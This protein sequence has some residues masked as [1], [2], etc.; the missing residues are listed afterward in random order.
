M[1]LRQSLIPALLTLSTLASAEEVTPTVTATGAAS[2]GADDTARFSYRIG[3]VNYEYDLYTLGEIDTV[4]FEAMVNGCNNFIGGHC[5]S[6]NQNY[7]DELFVTLK[8][9]GNQVWSDNFLV[10]AHNPQLIGTTYTIGGTATD[11]ML[12]FQ[13]YDKGYWAGNYGPTISDVTLSVATL[14]GIIDYGSVYDVPYMAEIELF[15]ETFTPFE[16]MFIPEFDM[17]T[18]DLDYMSDNETVEPE[19][20]VEVDTEMA[21]SDF[22]YTEED[23]AM[24]EDPLITETTI[25]DDLTI[26]DVTE[27]E[28]EQAIVEVSSTNATVNDIADVI[29]STYDPITQ[30]VALQIMTVDA[31]E[32][33]DTFLEDVEFYSPKTIKDRKLKDRIW[34]SI[35]ADDKR[36]NEMVDTQYDTLK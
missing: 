4:T 13:S 11:A 7:Y 28:V 32:F 25:D 33:K 8:I 6:T 1:W 35:Y 23:A 27:A 14:T 36:W 16:E 30:L 5:G 20:D 2:V 15:E 26:E 17:E 3:T 29:G 21:A 34:G 12:S 18:T 24:E 9:D 19:M 31:P 22:H 10:D